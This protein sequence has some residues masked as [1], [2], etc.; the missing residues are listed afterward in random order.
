MAKYHKGI[1][2]P[3]NPQKYRG[4]PT[5]IIFRS[6]WELTVMSWFDKHPSIIEW[7]S[8]ELRIPYRLTIDNSRHTYYPDF[9]IKKKGSDGSI[10]TIVIEVKP[11]KQTIPPKVQIN[12]KKPSKRYLNEVFEWSRNSS[13]WAAADA[14]CKNRGWQ[15]VVLTEDDIGVIK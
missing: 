6:S 10:S 1:F 13:K 4:D 11:K 15:F 9:V 14:Y 12:S 7:S 5:N 2:K 8:E 3:L